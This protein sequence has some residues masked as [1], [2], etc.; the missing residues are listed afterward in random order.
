MIIIIISLLLLLLLVLTLTVNSPPV[1]NI[2]A[3]Q[4]NYC[5]FALLG[6]V[7]D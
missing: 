4:F 2:M 5:C 7:Y 6:V 1:N 3:M